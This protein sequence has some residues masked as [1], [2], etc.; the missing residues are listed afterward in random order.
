MNEYVSIFELG[1]QIAEPMAGLDS[2]WLDP[3]AWVN[4]LQINEVYAKPWAKQLPNNTESFTNA[5]C[6]LHIYKI[7]F[8]SKPGKKNNSFPESINTYIHVNMHYVNKV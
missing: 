6:P 8:E 7:N 2:Q 3:K 4:L 5:I 1:L